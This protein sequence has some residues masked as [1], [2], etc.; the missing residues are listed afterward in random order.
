MNEFLIYFKVILFFI[1]AVLK[2]SLLSTMFIFQYYLLKDR[3]LFAKDL[4]SKMYFIYVVI[5]FVLE[6]ILLQ[7]WLLLSLI[8]NSIAESF[9]FIGFSIIIVL[10]IIEENLT[11]EEEERSL[12]ILLLIGMVPGLAIL[13]KYIFSIF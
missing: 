4:R 2:V 6:Y 7:R 5:L 3:T 10:S 9:I 1:G 11:R 8:I 12:K 13:L